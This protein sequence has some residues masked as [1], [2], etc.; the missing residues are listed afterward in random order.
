MSTNYYV[1]TAQ[2]PPD[3]EGIHLGKW[4]SGEFHFR[5]Y[6]DGKTRPAEVTWDVV[7]FESWSRLLGLGEVE[8]EAGRPVTAAEMVAEVQREPRSWR[9]AISHDQFTDSHGNR[10]SSC[11][12]C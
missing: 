1:R 5:A 7:D 9:P 12:F 3:A 4:A 6:P 2:T 10:F 8:T 11:E